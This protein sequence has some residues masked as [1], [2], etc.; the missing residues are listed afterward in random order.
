MARILVIE[1]DALLQ[2][3]IVAA[4]AHDHH[5]V[6]AAG[7][8]R[9]AEAKLRVQRPDLVITDIFMPER[10]GLETIMAFRNEDPHTPILAI[11]GYASESGLFLKVAQSLG[12][13]R[14]LAKPFTVPELL[15]A[16]DD[17]LGR[18]ASPR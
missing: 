18:A 7:N 11:S 9:E 13:K 12:A 4:L 15:A 16:V 6:V 1:D 10:D 8:G 3:V 14:T 5:E 17:V 2:Q